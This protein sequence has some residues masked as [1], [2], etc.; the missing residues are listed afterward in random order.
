MFHWPP[1]PEAS[2]PGGRSLTVD[3]WVLLPEDAEGEL[4]DGVLVEEE[5]PDAV[6]ELAVTWLIAAL[7]MWLAGQGF[8]FGSDLKVLTQKARGR[9]PD[10]SV[11]LPGRPPPP[12]RGPVREPPDVL[13]EVVTPTPRD[14]RRDRVEKMAEYADFG[15]HYYWIVD[16][17]LGTFEIFERAASGHYTKV[18]G[19]TSGNLEEVPGCQ[20]LTLDIDALWAELARL[21]E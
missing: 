6:H 10:L 5:V 15:V 13:V 21:A 3:E 7:R 14:E 16:P 9:K 12:R 18:V 4:V 17:S 11:Y 8:V 1:L 19:M 20:G 2:A